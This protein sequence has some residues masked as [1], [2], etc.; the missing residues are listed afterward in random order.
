M[1]TG[2]YY[3]YDMLEGKGYVTISSIA[4]LALYITLLVLPIICAVKYNCT[5]K[6]LIIPIH[7]VT[8]LFM[9]PFNSIISFILIAVNK[10]NSRYYENT[11][12]NIAWF[13]CGFYILS[14]LSVFMPMAKPRNSAGFYIEEVKDS[15]NAIDIISSSEFF[16][17]EI[18]N[19]WQFA[20]TAWICLPLVGLVLNLIFRDARKLIAVNLWIPLLNSIMV[21]LLANNFYSMTFMP[22]FGIGLNA[23]TSIA[24]AVVSYIVAVKVSYVDN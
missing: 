4:I 12:K 10:R 14:F 5:N 16:G 24:F 3:N 8:A 6:K 15:Y 21:Y 2:S 11:G 1:Y 17:E 18:T 7:I 13:Q 23:A 19:F 22:G 9:S 20:F